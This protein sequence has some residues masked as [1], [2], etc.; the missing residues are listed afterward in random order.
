M[1]LR[2]YLGIAAFFAPSMAMAVCPPILPCKV[3]AEA[4]TIAGSNADAELITFAQN[5]TTSTNQVAQ[6]LMDMANANAGALN[7]SALNMVSTN[8]ELSQITLN[9]KLQ[10]QRSLSDREMAHTQQMA[11]NDFR[12][13]SAVLSPDDTKEEFQLIIDT[14]NSN[15]NRSVPE[16]ILTLQETMDKDEQLGRV[17]VPLPGAEAVCTK[18]DIEE[19]GKC[20]VAKR[21][22]PGRKLE[23]FFK[24][25]SAEKR[26]LMNQK[27]VKQSRVVSADVSSK[28]MASAL[29]VVDSSGAIGARLQKQ[30]EL[31]CT[32]EQFKENLC[33]GM[34]P[35]QYQEDIVV[36]NIIPGGD[37]SA[38]NFNAPT[39]NSAAGYI[40][41]LTEKTKEEVEQQSL[42]RTDLNASP[43]QRVVPI[44]NTYRNANQVKSA[45]NFIDNIIADDLI[46]ALTPADRRKAKN[47]QYQSRYLSHAAAMSAVRLTLTTSMSTRVGDKMREM[48]VAGE[49]DKENKF[50]VSADSPGNKESVLGASPLDMLQDRVAQQ[51]S[52][53]QLGVQNG[54][55]SNVGNDFVSNP[56]QGST[57]DKIN[58]SLLLQSE[59]MLAEALTM[60][61]VL[62]L[63]S[64]QLSQKANSP[65]I[66]DL[67]DKLRRGAN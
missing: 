13:R 26:G 16:I 8:A 54:Q 27:K 63:E 25:C 34:S 67:M 28:K 15:S 39:S 37:V 9:Q 62:V 61:K 55:S 5:I 12:S 31:A 49:F 33:G 42:D 51:S 30:I 48:M 11:E 29:E 50:P 53:L 24:Q 22:Y 32:P 35:E 60:E 21:V 64:I 38:S 4:S 46:P 36:G 44:Q 57:M 2:L 1:N 20:A 56:S 45:M 52:E 6:A 66:V 47:A 3:T 43:N 7:Q 59:M 41:S 19:N 65:V 14:L 10:L 40:T 23:A 18:E 17:M 58:A